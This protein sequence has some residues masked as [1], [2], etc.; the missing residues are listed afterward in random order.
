MIMPQYDFY[1]KAVECC[2]FS[3]VNR[4]YLTFSA[5]LEKWSH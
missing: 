5:I 4:L 2:S 3:V 1:Q